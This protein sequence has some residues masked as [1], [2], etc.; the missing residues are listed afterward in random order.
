MCE[1][2]SPRTNSQWQIKP[3]I[4]QISVQLLMGNAVD[5]WFLVISLML[6]NG[7]HVTRR[8][9]KKHLFENWIN[10]TACLWKSH[11]LWGEKKA[12]EFEDVNLYRPSGDA[13]PKPLQATNQFPPRRP[14]II[15][16]LSGTKFVINF[17]IVFV[18]IC[19]CVCVLSERLIKK[20]LL[21]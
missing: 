3:M 13:R 2:T 5:G 8:T 16:N 9:L 12:N 21:Q 14:D 4:I 11:M 20:N 15:S 10:V 7:C 17:L 18:F 6:S 1:L 19:V